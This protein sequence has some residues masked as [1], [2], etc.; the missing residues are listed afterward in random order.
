MTP[1]RSREV[2]DTV[3]VESVR[4]ARTAS[5]RRDKSPTPNE[6]SEPLSVDPAASDPR[7]APP[8]TPIAF[9]DP[10]EDY[11]TEGDPYPPPTGV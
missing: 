10:D 6:F 9:P 2:S 7:L 4:P 8:G 3:Q 11:P 5:G 1:T